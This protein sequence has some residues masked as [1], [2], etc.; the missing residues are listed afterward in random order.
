MAFF[1]RPGRDRAANAS[2]RPTILVVTDDNAAYETVETVFSSL[3]AFEVKRSS[4]GAFVNEKL[5]DV[6]LYEIAIVDV[7]D[8]SWLA[9]TEFLSARDR[10]R[11]LPIIFFSDPLSSEVMR[12]LIRLDGVDWLQKPVVKRSL[13]ETVLAYTKKVKAAG[14][15]VHAVVS[16]GGGSGGTTVAVTMAHQYA[17]RRNKI[18]NSVA[19]FDMDFSKASCGAYLNMPNEYN[20]DTVIDQPE[21]VD[22]EFVDLINKRH[23]SGMSVFSFY[24]PEIG[25]LNQGRDLVLRML[26]VVAFQHDQTVVDLPFYE[27]TWKDNVLSSVNSVY[28]VTTTTVPGLEMAK[29][30]FQRA[31]RLRKSTEG[32]QILVNHHKRQFFGS[33]PGRKQVEKIFGST[34][35]AFLPS[36]PDVMTEAVN[37]GVLPSEVNGR[38]NFGAAVASIIKSSRTLAAV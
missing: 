13:I 15:Q 37:R 28:I 8:G 16:T 20:L 36:E 10:V 21:R 29:L 17:L 32:I 18:G 14:G 31:A 11:G 26:D 25:I 35:V 5:L 3:S 24:R 38:T 23:A 2:T 27:T 30:A 9:K 19:L 33:E 12:Q 4:V 1:N 22:V 34:K 6:D 7:G